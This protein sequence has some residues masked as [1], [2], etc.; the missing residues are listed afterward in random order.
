MKQISVEFRLQRIALTLARMSRG[1]V[2]FFSGFVLMVIFTAI[3]L[4]PS[5]LLY[6]IFHIPSLAFFII[7]LDVPVGLFVLSKI[8]EILETHGFYS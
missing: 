6:L 1:E 7:F 3:I 2:G 5:I 4:S 8:D